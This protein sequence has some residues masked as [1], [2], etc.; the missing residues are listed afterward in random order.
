MKSPAAALSPSLGRL[1]LRL[2]GSSVARLRSQAS[3]PASPAMLA[4]CARGRLASGDGPEAQRG[5]PPL[6]PDGRRARGVARTSGRAVLGAQGRG[7]VVDPEGGVRRGRGRAGLRAARVRGGDGHGAARERADRS[8]HRAAEER[9]GGHRLGR[10]GRPR[11]GRDPEQHVRAGM[12][13]ALGQDAGLSGGGPCRLVRSRRGSGQA[14]SRPDGLPRPP[15]RGARGR[16]EDE[17]RGPGQREERSPIV[18]RA[19]TAPMFT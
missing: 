13:A 3:L 16:R 11:R 7:R 8:G 15:A 18:D 4:S 9:Q 10:R 1:R 5:H 2:A 19:S 14:Q 6:S 12:A 17:Q